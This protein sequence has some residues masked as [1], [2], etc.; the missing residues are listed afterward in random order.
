MSESFSP[1]NSKE[2]YS[3][4]SVW[5]TTLRGFLAEHFQQEDVRDALREFGKARGLELGEANAKYEG[6]LS[7]AY[8][9]MHALTQFGYDELN[10][11]PDSAPERAEQALRSIPLEAS[12]EEYEMLQG[13]PD[14]MRGQLEYFFHRRQETRLM[15]RWLFSEENSVKALDL[16]KRFDNLENEAFKAFKELLDFETNTLHIK[17]TSLNY[18]V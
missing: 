2:Q 18:L 3:K 16:M 14:S 13:Q 9:K 5:E 7:D 12:T 10:I 8:F 6:L 4:E 15:L 17:P 11:D 1:E